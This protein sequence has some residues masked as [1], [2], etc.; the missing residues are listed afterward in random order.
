MLE[1]ALD[2][3]DPGAVGLQQDVEARPE[4]SRPPQR[5]VEDEHEAAD[6]RRRA[7]CVPLRA[8]PPREGG[9]LA[10]LRGVARGL[11][12]H[13]LFTEPGAHVGRLAGGVVET[14]A[15]DGVGRNHAARDFE[16]LRAGVECS[17]RWQSAASRGRRQ[18]RTW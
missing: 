15:E 5:L 13:G 2:A 3:Q 11:H 12:S 10:P 18:G 6:V 9:G 8:A 7:G 14:A 17:S 4:K 16:L 1:Q